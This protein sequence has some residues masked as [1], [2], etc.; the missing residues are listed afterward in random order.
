MCQITSALESIHSKNMAA[1][2]LNLSKI[3][4]TS[5]HRVRLNCVAINDLLR[6]DLNDDLAQS[7]QEDLSAFGQV[8]LSLACNSLSVGQNVAKAVEMVGKHYSPELR[9]AISFLLSKPAPSK[10][11]RELT[12]MIAPQ[13]L[14]ESRYLSRYVDALEQELSKELENSRLFRLICKLGFIN[15]RPEFEAD[16]LWAETGDRYLLKLFR[17]FLFHQ[18]DE[19]G[20]PV[21]D[22]GHVVH[23]LNKLDA[24]DQEKI[25]LVSRDELSCLIVAYKDLKTC[26]E[27]AFGD[28]LTKRSQP[29]QASQ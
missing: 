24:G 21:V 2:M 6:H 10:N 18:V 20:D 8:M 7:Q 1:R 11:I 5:K 23:C 28:L 17:D 19:N 12:R 13:L 16:P 14:I 4:L 25:V 26:I 22:L 27:S 9:S 15:E 3:L 29:Q